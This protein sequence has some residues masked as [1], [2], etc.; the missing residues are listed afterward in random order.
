MD[1][2]R[3]FTLAATHLN[4]SRTASVLFLTPSAVSRQLK[5]LEEQM[6]VQLFVRTNRGLCLT[7]PGQ[8]LYAQIHEPIAQIHLATTALLPVQKSLSLLVDAAFAHTWLVKRLP[9]FKQRYPSIEL[10]LRLGGSMQTLTGQP[11]QAGVDV[12]IVYGAPPWPG[13]HSE[14]LLP[15]QEFPV[16]SPTL[17]QG[18]APLRTPADLP[19][20]TMIHEGD[21]S[22]WRRWLAAAHAS[23]WESERSIVAHDS[24][25]CLSMAV[26]GEGVAIGDNL[27]CAD[28]LASGQ[29]VKPF[30]KDLALQETFHLVVHQE[31][32]PGNA[33][34]SF[35]NWLLELL[36][37]PQ[38]TGA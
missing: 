13:F 19:Q 36:P 15:F 35:C 25:T 28:Y 14:P 38:L 33:V 8:Q 7:D 18:G 31:K 37:P 11:L 20:H 6:Q 27:T 32:D 23:P 9:Q 30:A 34:Q 12:L 1:L 22:T 24:L 3:T 29:L 26:A 16:C 5:M 4:V 17:L 10:D 21:R 2:L